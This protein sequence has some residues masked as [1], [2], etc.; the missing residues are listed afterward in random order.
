MI[1]M[2][3]FAARGVISMVMSLP[4]SSLRGLR[5]TSVLR[6]KVDENDRIDVVPVWLCGIVLDV[7]HVCERPAKG[8]VERE[9]V[10]V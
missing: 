10:L 8:S 1:G 7:D 3:T 6:N 4:S 5:I 9:A 2:L